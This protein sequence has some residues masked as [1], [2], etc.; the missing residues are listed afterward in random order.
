MPQ[1]NGVELADLIKQKYSNIF[2]IALSSLAEIEKLGY[3]FDCRL[4]KPVKYDKLL[5]SIINLYNKIPNTPITNF[6]SIKNS[7]LIGDSLINKL[8]FNI[9]IA[10]DNYYNRIV[11]KELLLSC[12]ILNTN[13]TM[14]DD[15]KK[16]INLLNVNKYDMLFLDI[17][18][19]VLNGYEVCD[20]IN[21]KNISIYIVALTAH[22]LE[23]E[24]NKCLKL[25][26]M[27]DFLCKPITLIN[28]KNI[29]KN[30]KQYNSER[31]RNI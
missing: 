29:I 20:Y 8:N 6:K 21:L 10:E 24:R 23:N 14:V 1:I 16:T 5:S 19:P 3:N 4:T 11:I 2:I 7:P 27:N 12:G 25:Y 17:K 28:I 13:I 18:M 30:Y 26:N 22:A 9:L 15:G 31:I